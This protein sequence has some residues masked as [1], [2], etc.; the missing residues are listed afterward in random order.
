MRECGRCSKPVQTDR[1][2]A[3]AF[4]F[5]FHDD[6]M[7]PLLL[8]IIPLAEHY[9]AYIAESFEV[10]HIP[11]AANRA[12]V[13]AAHGPAIRVVLTNGAIGLTA[14]EIDAM[15]ALDII[16]SFGVGTENIDVAHAK[17]RGIAMANGAGTNDDCVADHALGLLLAVVRAIPRNNAATRAG[18]WRD[19]LPLPPQV[20][21][22]RLGVIGLGSIG[23]KIAQ[24]ALGFDMAVGYHNRSA[25]EDAPYPY[26]ETPLALA[27]WA[28]FIVVATPGGASTRHLINAEVLT[29][30]GPKG[31]LVN[32]GRGSTVDTAA[33][34]EALRA[35]RIAGAGLDV[36]EGEPAPPEALMAFDNVV[37]TPHLAGWS[38]EAIGA[39]VQRFIDNACGHLAGRGAV[40]PVR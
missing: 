23:M 12:A 37:L 9:R 35:G 20:A 4:I 32:I 22:R 8:I 5:Y 34:A 26:F 17:Q 33:L 18:V 10:L 38:P 16:C 36:Y 11:Q 1:R 28:D 13:L 29:A 15:P 40:S 25:R 6:A 2:V 14:A 31:F 24:R 39:S 21:R 3:V 30:L 7:K 19:A 27:D